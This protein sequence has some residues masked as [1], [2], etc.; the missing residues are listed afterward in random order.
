M[1]AL[2]GRF[3]RARAGNGG[4]KPR[5]AIVAPTLAILGGQAVQA[6]AI[7]RA[8]AAAGHEVD[9]V[10]VNPVFPG[11]LARLRRWPY[12]RTIVNQ[13]LYLPALRRL[14]RADVV[15]VFS[16]AYW[17]FVL[18]PLPALVAARLAGRP[19]VLNYHSGEADDHLARWGA[20]VHPWL[21]LADAIVVPSTYLRDVFARHGHV[22]RVVPNAVDVEGFRYRERSPLAP[23][24]LSVRNFEPHY[25]VAN[26]LEAFRLVAARVPDATLTLAGGGSEEPSLRRLAA[27]LGERVRF[28]GSVPPD[29]MADVYAACDVFLNSSVVDNQPISILE[30]FA[31]GLPVVSTPTGGIATMVRDGDTGLLVRADDPAAMAAAVTS[32][33]GDAERACAMARRARA[34]VER[35]TWARVGDAWAEVYGAARGGPEWSRACA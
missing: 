17:S 23:R 26:T 27:P 16:A 5:I 7:A 10:P 33:L 14:R 24:L 25:R 13:A 11:P 30:A 28:V 32:L 2:A 31:A 15:H 9:F 1:G 3:E 22:A 20:L 35:F 18:A 4:M 6:Q 21:R 29:R 34:A 19:V 8:L 12:V